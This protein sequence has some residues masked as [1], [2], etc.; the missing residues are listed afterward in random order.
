MEEIN[1][2]PHE[3][4]K[5]DL[6]DKFTATATYVGSHVKKTIIDTDFKVLKQN[7]YPPE[8]I[9]KGDVIVLPQGSKN[10]PC[11]IAKVLK[12]RTCIYIPL[13]STD[14]LHCLTPYKSRF[15]KEGC[16][17]K[18][19]DICSEEKA[20]QSFVGVFDNMRALNQAVKELK[21]FI[22]INL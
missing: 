16:F 12:D 20:I 9:K 2:P 22:N 14:N 8:Q 1:L 15:F 17:C 7:S 6:T 5:R 10:R 4:L 18:T 11:V 13:T 3:K 19:I 21:S